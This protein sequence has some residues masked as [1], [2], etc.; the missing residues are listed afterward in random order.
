[1]DISFYY[2]EYVNK[3]QDMHAQMRDKMNKDGVEW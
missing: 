1:M 3:T 2:M